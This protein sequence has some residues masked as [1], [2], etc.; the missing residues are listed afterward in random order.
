[1]AKKRNIETERPI[2]GIAESVNEQ[3]GIGSTSSGD[4]KPES[5]IED[6]KRGD[7]AT[8][9]FSSVS[10][11]DL[12]GASSGSGASLG[13]GDAPRRRGRAPGSKNKQ[14]TAAAD[15]ITDLTGAICV[16]NSILV[17]LTKCDEFDAPREQVEVVAEKVRNFAQHF[18]VKLDPV[19]LAGFQLLVAVGIMYAPGIQA[20]WQKG[21]RSRPKLVERPVAEMP[22]PEAERTPKVA[23]KVAQVPSEVWD[24]AP[25]ED[26]SLGTQ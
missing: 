26:L 15:L 24:G 21:V 5:R 1:M 7:E 3:S 19:K 25:E 10:P 16:T 11:I 8:T 13:N 20:V 6:S 23:P 22:K 18:S 12:G 2:G 17:A 14:T 9:G 4:P